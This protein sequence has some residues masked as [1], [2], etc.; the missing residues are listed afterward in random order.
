MGKTVC[1][2]CN[3][4]NQC[5]NGNLK[6]GGKCWCTDKKFPDEVF[7]QIPREELHKRCV[8]QSCLKRITAGK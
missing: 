7:G 3:G 2:I 1:P 5:G 4:H 8:C 6:D